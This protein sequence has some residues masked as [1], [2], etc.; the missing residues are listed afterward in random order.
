VCRCMAGREARR[1]P[2]R[3][4][5]YRLLLARATLSRHE[6]ALQALHDLGRPPYTQWERLKRLREWADRLADG[7]DLQLRLRAIAP[8][9]GRCP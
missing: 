5:N 4:C 9:R 7:D 8:H 2:R 6:E 3:P 1:C